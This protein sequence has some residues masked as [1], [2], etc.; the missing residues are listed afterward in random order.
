LRLYLKKTAAAVQAAAAALPADDPRRAAA[1]SS[2]AEAL[3]RAETLKPGNGLQ[4]AFDCARGLA[5]AAR[6]LRDHK[7]A[8]YEGNSSC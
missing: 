4:S 6:E 7:K 8:L 3:H 1:E 2:A 5:L